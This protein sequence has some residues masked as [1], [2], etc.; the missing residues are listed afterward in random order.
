MLAAR[1]AGTAVFML[2]T[3][4]VESLAELP[5]PSPLVPCACGP[6]FG[7][8]VAASGRLICRE[9]GRVCFD[10]TR[11]PVTIA[12]AGLAGRGTKVFVGDPSLSGD[13]GNVRE[14]CDLGD[15]T[16]PGTGLRETVLVA[17][18][19]SAALLAAPVLARF[20][21]LSSAISVGCSFS[22]SET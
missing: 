17:F 18:V 16:W 13:C 19:G 8:S 1:A 15:R 12:L 7:A 22:L 6:G 10:G 3:T 9:T 4:V 5:R 21:G 11:G 2:V 14:F 20:L